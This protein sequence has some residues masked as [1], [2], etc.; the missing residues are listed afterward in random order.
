MPN[1]TLQN[2]SRIQNSSVELESL[3]GDAPHMML[4]MYSVWDFI[5]ILDFEYAGYVFLKWGMQNASRLA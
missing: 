1:S 4:K 2:K 3:L 5:G